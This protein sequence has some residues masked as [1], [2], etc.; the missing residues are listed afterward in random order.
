V[1]AKFR[2]VVASSVKHAHD[3]HTIFDGPIEDEVIANWQ[4]AE[5]RCEIRPPLADVWMGGKKMK[6][7]LNR[8]Q[9]TICCG[10]VEGADE[11]PDCFEIALC[12]LRDAI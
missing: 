8:L 11:A 12:R 6:S 9:P 1:S 7:L 5:F 10:G 3:L 2:S 4:E